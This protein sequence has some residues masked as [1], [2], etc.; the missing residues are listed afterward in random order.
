MVIDRSPAMI[1]RLLAVLK[2]GAAFLPIDPALPAARIAEMTDGARVRLLLSSQRLRG[3]V[4]TAVP[5]LEMEDAEHSDMVPSAGLS[6]VSLQELPAEWLPVPPT[7]LPPGLP[8]VL[9]GQLAYLIYTSGSTGTPK[10][11]AVEHGPLAMHCH[12]T[13]GQYGMAP[14]ERELHFLAFGFDGAHERWM[15][16]LVAGAEVVLRDDELWSAEQTLDA[17]RRHG[18]TN[19]GFPPAYLMRLVEA[20]RADAPPLRLLS[21]GGEAISRESFARVRDTFR[22]RTLINGYGPTEA[23]VTPLAW[24]TDGQ[25][26]CRQAYAPIGRPVGS[27]HAYVLDGD[28]NPVPYGAIGE[29]YIG[30]FGLARGYAHRAALTAERFLPD[31]F[32]PGARMYRT[33]DLVRQAADGNVEYVARRD[34]QVKI[35]G[36]RIE[37]G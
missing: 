2:A 30:G 6:E 32:A 16:P 5:V 20:A 13:A 15:A 25:E 17:F 28:L 9:R 34:H 12:A 8:P 11:V 31:P 4:R 7:V 1:V 29:L 37:P 19:A 27:R 23:V 21:F 36:Y 26:D 33:G 14:G 3:R 35:R 24:V 22:A 10:A 18:I